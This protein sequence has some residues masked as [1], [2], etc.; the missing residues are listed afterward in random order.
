M[1]LRYFFDPKLAHASYMVACQ[2]TGE[3]IIIDPGRNVALYLEAAAAEGVTIV[4]AA[5][6]HL[7]ADFVSGCRELAERVG[8][9]LYLSA[10]GG[11]DWQYQFL[12]DYPVCL[13]KDGDSWH[14]GHIKFEAIHTPGHTPE[15]LAF[16]VTDGTA[17]AVPMGIFSGDF[18]FAGDVGRPDLLET[19]AG[20]RG[21]KEE[22]ARALFHSL[23]CFKQLPDYLQ[24]WPSHGAGSACG[25]ALGAIPSSTVGYERLA[26]WAFQIEDEASFVAT[27]LADQPE[28][29]RYFA[30]MKRI[31]KE[32]PARLE[33]EPA[34]PRLPVETLETLRQAGAPIMDARS[35]LAFAQGHLPGAFNNPFTARTFITYAGSFLDYETPFYLI[36]EEVSLKEAVMDLRRIG[37]DNIAGYFSPE[38]VAMW[39]NQ[40]G[41]SL[42][43]IPQVTVAEVVEDVK[44]GRVAVIDVRGAA[45]FAAGHVPVA[46]NIALT[47]LL[48]HLAEIP[49]DRPVALQCW[50][51]FRSSIAAGLL[52]SRGRTN[53]MNLQGGYQAW[54]RAM[55]PVI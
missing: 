9:V 52:A 50:S 20:I 28:P 19:A 44:A 4:A 47:N 48:D 3:A 42:G 24:I 12:T 55:Q 53:I 25:K 10:E 43:H 39:A 29:P 41:H 45:E 1:L 14:I 32:G 6:T 11:A 37:L 27:V 38:T 35:H 54:R 31:N 13:L 23:Q 22:G 51:G 33:D 2:A 8:A 17:L 49:T 36:I 26:N 30:M 46:R 15:H 18:V 16:K 34:P 40:T 21:A 5:E 7:H